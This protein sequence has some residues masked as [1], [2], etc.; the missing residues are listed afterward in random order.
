MSNFTSVCV[1]SY[2]RPHYLRACLETLRDAG[3]PFE[4]IVHDDGSTNPELLA[5]LHEMQ[6]RGQFS[7][8]IMNQPGHNQGVGCAIKRCF[9]VAQG[10]VLV[11]VDQ[12]LVFQSGWLT[13]VREIL[14][15]P[16]VGLT[17]LFAYHHDPVDVAKTKLDGIEP[18]DDATWSYHTHIC[19]SAFAI[20]RETYER[21]GIETHS[22]AFAE[23]WDLMK[24]L[25][26]T[27]LVCALPN[28]ALVVNVGFGIGPS[29]VVVAE[30]T[31]QTIKHKPHLFDG[32]WG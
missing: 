29:T 19:G 6:A 9:D 11:K 2:E 1:L 3:E 14:A 28:E 4:L 20:T 15:D 31:V 16:N 27:E 26:A 5:F 30:N 32:H 12:D 18:P 10:D 13:R 17:G 23:D 22:D 7:T 21:F 8:L 25:S 24:R